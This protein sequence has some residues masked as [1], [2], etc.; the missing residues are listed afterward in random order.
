MDAKICGVKNIN[1]LNYLLKHKYPPKYIGFICNYPKS[2]RNL[3]F[4]E[5]KKLIKNRKK[6]SNLSQFQL[7]Q[8]TVL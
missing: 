4:E 8:I 3:N 5:L 6:K 2:N 7:N 1:T